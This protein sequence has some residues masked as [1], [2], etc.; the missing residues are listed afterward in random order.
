MIKGAVV[1]LNSLHASEHLRSIHDAVLYGAVFGIPQRRAG[2]LIEVAV[3]NAET[4]GLPE[5]I[6]SF[7]STFLCLNVATLLNAR[8]SDMN[9]HILLILME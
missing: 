7:K 2:T 5:N 6:L 9:C 8:F 3:V 4:I 1:Y